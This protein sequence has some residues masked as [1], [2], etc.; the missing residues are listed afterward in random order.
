MSTDR[1]ATERL[2]EILRPFASNWTGTL[3]R[4]DLV[5]PQS[6]IPRLIQEILEVQREAGERRSEVSE[7]ELFAVLHDA[8]RLASL[9]DRAARLRDAFFISKR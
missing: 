4:G 7:H 6:E 3:G 2:L 1:S 5:I 8:C 9:Q